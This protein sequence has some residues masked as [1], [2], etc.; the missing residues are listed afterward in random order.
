[1]TLSD[2]VLQNYPRQAADI[3]EVGDST[4]MKAPDGVLQNYPRQATDVVEV[5]DSTPM[6]AP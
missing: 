4:P 3:V 1:M 5:G 6:K 2:G